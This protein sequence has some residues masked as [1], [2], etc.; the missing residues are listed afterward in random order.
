MRVD[1][2]RCVILAAMGFEIADQR[3]FE[4]AVPTA[5]QL[6]A[7]RHDAM[8]IQISLRTEHRLTFG[9]LPTLVC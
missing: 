9:T 2:G 3:R 8:S 1:D 7:V 6:H 4:V 5:H